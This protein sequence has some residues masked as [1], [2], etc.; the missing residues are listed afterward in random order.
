M[1]LKLFLVL[2][3]ILL[4]TG[5]IFILLYNTIITKRNQVNNAFSTIDVNLK[6]RRDLIPNLVAVAKNYLIFEQSILTEIA[7]IRSETA[8]KRGTRYYKLSE[9]EISRTIDRIIITIE[10][11]PELKADKHFLN[12]QLSLNEVEEQISAARRFYNT[13]VKEYNNAIEIFPNNL[14]AL[15]MNYKKIKLF[16]ALEEDRRNVNISKLLN[17]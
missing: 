14:I 13:A 11:Y 6:K 5:I 3:I 2:I 17:S 15:V 16:I 1:L 12:L 9:K 4:I 7:K 10:S 8:S